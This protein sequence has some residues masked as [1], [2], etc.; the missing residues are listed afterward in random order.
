MIEPSERAFHDLQDAIEK[1]RPPYGTYYGPGRYFYWYL[2]HHMAANDVL[3]ADVGP[4]RDRTDHT[5]RCGRLFV[6]TSR[7]FWV[8]DY[9]GAI[10]EPDGTNQGFGTANLAMY[11]REPGAITSVEW[12]ERDLRIP[13]PPTGA[14]QPGIRIDARTI[15]LAGKGWTVQLPGESLYGADDHFARLRAALEVN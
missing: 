12:P 8:I 13:S 10:D 3:F 11:P 9:S 2:A 6:V 5:T 7:W 15:T 1:H 14:T 4:D